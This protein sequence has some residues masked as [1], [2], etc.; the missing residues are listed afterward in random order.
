MNAPCNRPYRG[1]SL[2]STGIL[3]QCS[4][5]VANPGDHIKLGCFDVEL[6][7]VNHSIPDAVAPC[8]KITRR[9]RYTDGRFQN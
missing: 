8:Y 7:H 3:K 5:N 6:I 2:K 1:A 9:N 4:L